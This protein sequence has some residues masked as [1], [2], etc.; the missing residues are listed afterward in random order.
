MDPLDVLSPATRAWFERAFAAPTPAQ[1]HA[2]PA[3]ASGEHVLVQAPTGS[4]K[5]LAAFLVGI[6]RLDD[7]AR[8]GPPA[9]LR[10]AAEGAQLRR[11]AQ[12]ARAARRARLA[13]SRSACA[14]ATRRQR[15]RQQMLRTP[16][17]ILITT[18]ESLFLLLTSQAREMLRTVETRDPRRGARGRRHEAR[19]AP[20]ALARAAR[21]ARRA[22]VPAD[23][24]LGDAAAARGDR[25]LRRRARDGRSGSSTRATARS[26]TSR[27]W[28]RSRTCASSARN[29]DARRSR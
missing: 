12:P 6:D 10:L 16:P 2:W 25:P 20:R 18:P 8:R 26:S 27:S 19:R 28:S 15:E 7:D 29:R 17:D 3:I 11:R 5:T 21:G 23:R 14:P 4:G 1:E 9:P 22:A 24:A 13:R